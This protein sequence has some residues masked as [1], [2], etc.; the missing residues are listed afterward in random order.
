MSATVAARLVRAECHRVMDMATLQARFT[1]EGRLYTR[2]PLLA[3]Q[4][5]GTGDEAWARC[6]DAYARLHTGELYAVTA[7]M[8]ACSDEDNTV[9]L[10]GTL[11]IEPLAAARV[12]PL[13]AAA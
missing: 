12:H 1:Q 2:S 7:E 11:R 10:L 13:K 5:F 9:L 6:L 3:L 4:T 8:L